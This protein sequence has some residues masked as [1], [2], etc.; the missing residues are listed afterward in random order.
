MKQDK[1]TE[2]A[3]NGKG[4]VFLDSLQRPYLLKNW[5]GRVWLFAWH[6]DNHWVSYRELKENEI[7]MIPNNLTQAEQDRY[8]ELNDKFMA[9]GSTPAPA[10]G[11]EDSEEI[12]CGECGAVLEPNRDLCGSCGKHYWS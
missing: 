12:R 7:F 9:R 5:G 4:V 2:D 1:Q 8:H 3:I 10:A 6:P 11:D